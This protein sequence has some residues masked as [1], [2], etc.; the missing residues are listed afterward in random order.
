VAAAMAAGFARRAALDLP[1]RIFL[2]AS[3]VFLERFRLSLVCLYVRLVQKDGFRILRV[4]VLVYIVWK[5]LSTS[6][7]TLNASA[8]V[9]L[10]VSSIVHLRVVKC[11][12]QEPLIQAS[13][14][15]CIA[16]YAAKV[17]LQRTQAQNRVLLVHLDSP[18]V[19]I[20]FCVCRVL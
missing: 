14:Q 18:V 4:P 8:C 19:L 12:H 1:S 13:N 17:L 16:A 10:V 5:D 2:L 15:I 6:I 3:S 9:A 11:A 7:I 20:A